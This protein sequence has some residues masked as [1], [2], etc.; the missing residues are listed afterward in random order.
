MDARVHDACDADGVEI[1]LVLDG[2]PLYVRRWPSRDLAL[3][4]ATDRLR[5]LQRAGWST[6]W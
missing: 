4:D 6:H 3:A 1:R 5:D 2:E